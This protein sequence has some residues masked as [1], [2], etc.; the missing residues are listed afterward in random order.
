MCCWSAS[1]G[2]GLDA[3]RL[4]FH[5]AGPNRVNPHSTQTGYGNARSMTLVASLSPNAANHANLDHTVLA[6]HVSAI[7]TPQHDP[8]EMLELVRVPYREALNLALRGAIMQ[9]THVASL[10]LGLSAAG[11]I[12][13]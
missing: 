1:T 8:T 5:A 6:E 9:S 10:M 3:S 11:K 13:P 12:S 4:S 7:A 2:T